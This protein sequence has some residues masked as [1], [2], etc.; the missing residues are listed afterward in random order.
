MKTALVTGISGQD[1]SYLAQLLLAKNYRV[2]GGLRRNA[3][4]SLWRLEELG[5]RNDVEITPWDMLELPLMLRTLERVKPDE[6]YNLA[7]Q[8]QVHSSFDQPLTTADINAMG[9]LRLLETIRTVCPT[10]RMYQ[11]SSSEMFGDAERHCVKCGFGSENWSDRTQGCAE[12][13]CIH[14]VDGDWC[15]GRF[16]YSERSQ[17][18]PRSPYAFSKLLAYWA[19]RNYREAYGMHASNGILMNHESPLR[20]VEFVTRKITDGV[21]RIACGEDYVIKLG[22]LEAKRDW[23]FAGD[24]VEAMFLMLQQEKADDY[25]IA[26]GETHSVR[27]CLE[28]VLDAAGIRYQWAPQQRDE[29]WQLWAPRLIAIC[30]LTLYRPTEVDVLLGDASKARRVLGWQPK[31]TFTEL[32][33]MMVEADMRR[34]RATSGDI[35]R[36]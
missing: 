16:A 10:V 6:I 32:V 15:R 28:V 14:H 12:D 35:E 11:A 26:T 30:D 4:G 18:Q 33:A 8:S 5:I 27:E 2:V 1:G 19:V 20:S 3:S 36:R 29:P 21:A 23:G 34:H 9:V 13:L 25:V 24:F 22:N 7:A 17:F 31:T